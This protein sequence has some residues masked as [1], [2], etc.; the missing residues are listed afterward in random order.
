MNWTKKIKAIGW[1]LDRTLYPPGAIPDKMFVDHQIKV[2]MKKNNW[3]KARAEREYQKKYA[4]YG[5]HTKALASLGVDGV[6]FFLDLWDELPLEKYLK[7]DDR[8]VKMF[9]KLSG[10]EHFL[11]TNGGYMRQIKK[12]LNLIGL[13]GSEFKFIVS[14]YLIKAP[15]PELKPFKEAVKQSELKPEEILYVGDRD[16]A[17]I[18]PAKL[19]GMKTCMVWDKSE[20]AD[21]S[22]EN[23]YQVESLFL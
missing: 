9:E 2:V 10:Y 7:K 21:V 14:G 3:D 6:Q 11:V 19:V 18:I 8:L 13:S 4:S 22:L 15:K 20:I 1:D 17:D 16:K 5:S 12:K 23:V